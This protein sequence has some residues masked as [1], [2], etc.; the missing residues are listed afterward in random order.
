M[1]MQGIQGAGGAARA[2]RGQQ[3]DG[4][5]GAD[6]AGDGGPSSDSGGQDAGAMV[7]RHMPGL[8]KQWSSGI[9]GG[10]GG[11]GGASGA[12]GAGGASGAGGES[13]G[14]SSGGG[15]ASPAAGAGAGG[16]GGASGAGESSGSGGDQASGAGGAAAASAASS[17]ASS[18]GSGASSK[19]I[20]D[21]INVVRAEAGLSPVTES[22]Q[23]DD[24][25]AQ[26]EAANVSSGDPGH[27]V[28]LT[29]AAGEGQGQ[30]VAPTSPGESAESIV[31]RW[32]DS[33]GHRDILMNPDFKSIGVATSDISATANFSSV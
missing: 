14:S 6:G 31:Q 28:A 21:R 20:I 25:A 17:A 32:M 26:N 8:M 5:Q 15:G 16:S 10:C 33:P 1:G 11:G 18:S 24:S 9:D 29:P 7:D 3:A 4:A 27:H 12:G 30:T 22:A 13:G 19:A 23:L 2:G